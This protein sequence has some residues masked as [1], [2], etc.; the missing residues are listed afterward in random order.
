MKRSDFIKT[1]KLS[2]LDGL[3]GVTLIVDSQTA[4]LQFDTTGK[5]V[6]IE[7]FVKNGSLDHDLIS[8]QQGNF[9]ISRV[10][11]QLLGV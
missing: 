5:K 7:T 1:F 11:S 3:E 4:C 6:P 10:P 2:S 9:E 8:A